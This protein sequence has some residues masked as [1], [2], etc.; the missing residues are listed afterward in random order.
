MSDLL[1]ERLP[2]IPRTTSMWPHNVSV[3]Y[4]ILAKGYEFALQILHSEDRD[5]LQLQH[6]S[7]HIGEI[8]IPILAVLEAEGLLQSWLETCANTLGG[9]MVELK[10][11]AIGADQK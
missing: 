7:A 10:A 4:G 9:L 8:F 3:A 2:L 11:A 6:H 1:P 5:A